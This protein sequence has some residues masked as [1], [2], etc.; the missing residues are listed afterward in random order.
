MKTQ[1]FIPTRT[2]CSQYEIEITF[3][4]DLD[5]M[6]LIQIE[7]IE[8]EPSIHHDQLS[9]LEKIMRLYHELEL[10]LE[11]IDVVFHLLD[12]Q[13]AL[14]NEIIFLKNRLKLYEDDE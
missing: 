13:Q 9:R 12:Q 10:N 5:K 1:D 7:L 6:G 14:R 2:L 11:G 3:V 4:N 8:E